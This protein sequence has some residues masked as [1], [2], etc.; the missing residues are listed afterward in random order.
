MGILN[1]TP[2][3]FSD[4][5]QYFGFDAAMDRA[6]AMAKEGASII[7]VGGEST[8]PGSVSVS[9]KE[10]IDRVMPVIQKLSQVLP[11]NI[12][13]SID[14][15]KAQVAAA[16]LASGARM[17]NDVTALRGDADMV[18]IVARAQCP[19]VLMYA[20]DAM[21]RTTR[22]L[23]QYDDVVRTIFLFLQERIDYAV[24]A[25]VH[26]D[27][28]VIDPGM[29]AFVSGDARYSFEILQRLHEF[30]V[31]KKLILV[32]ASRK[33]FLG[34]TIADRC[35]AGLACAALAV[36]HGASIIRTHDVQETVRALHAINSL[37]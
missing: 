20:K 30:S 11:K 27:N 36:A 25:G 10:E 26:L 6:C 17:V 14:T 12:I 4:G 28:I 21:P 3:S 37:S 8:G 9:P 5:G 13:I 32:G 34:G 33:S 23:V 18:K 19:I 15:W 35:E 22:D 16:A 7:D 31:F 29:G 1:I 2:D 24:R